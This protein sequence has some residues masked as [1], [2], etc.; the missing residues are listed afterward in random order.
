M[1][2]KRRAPHADDA[3]LLHGLDERVERQG[4]PVRR[5]IGIDFLGRE[6]VGLDLDRWREA[7]VRAAKIADLPTTPVTGLCSAVDTNPPGSAISCPRSTDSPAVTTARDGTPMCCPSGMTNC[8]PN[9][10]RWMGRC[11]VCCL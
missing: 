4:A 3:G 10:T 11:S 9:G 6:R 2:R 7:A 1:G 5:G 8:L